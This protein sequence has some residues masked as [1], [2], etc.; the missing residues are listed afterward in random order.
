M[1]VVNDL[2]EGIRLYLNM[3][4]GA[5][6]IREIRSFEDYDNMQSDFHRLQDW[7]GDEI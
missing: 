1:I 3:F 5:I 7:S 4:A 2:P 6:I